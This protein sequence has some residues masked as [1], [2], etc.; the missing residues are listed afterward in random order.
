[1]G[2]IGRRTTLTDEAQDQENGPKKATLSPTA[3]AAFLA[4]ARVVEFVKLLARRAAE[5][6]DQSQNR[7][8][9]HTHEN[10]ERKE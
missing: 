7:W 1:M 2:A 10:V 9:W 8:H 3:N 4:D 6:D 5:H